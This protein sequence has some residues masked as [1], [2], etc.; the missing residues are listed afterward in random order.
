VAHAG[1]A[2]EDEIHEVI[3]A[4]YEIAADDQT[5]MSLP[6]IVQAWGYR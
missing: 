1:L 2:T 5:V 4:L 6:R 3:R